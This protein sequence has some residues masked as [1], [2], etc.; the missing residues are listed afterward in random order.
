[1]SL[2]H[3]ASLFALLDMAPP[4]PTVHE[5]SESSDYCSPVAFEPLNRSKPKATAANANTP[6]LK[7]PD[8]IFKCVMDYLDGSA[9]WSLKRLC[10]GMESSITV[11]QLL[12][13]YPL[14]LSDVRDIRLGDWKYRR[15][16]VTRWVSFKESITDANRNYVQ[17][18]AMSHF[19]SI[20]DFR[21]IEEHLPSLTCLDIS[22]IKDFVWTPEE[23]W[24]WKMMAEACPKLFGRLEEL[25]VANWADYTAHS[26]IEYS[27]SYNDY[28]FK[29][30]FRISRRRDG[31]SVAKMIFPICTKLKLLAIRERY[32]GFHTWNEWEVHQRVCCLVDG[33]EKYCPESMTK[34][35][36]H[37]YAPYRSLFSTDATPWKRL[38]HVEIGLSSWMEDRRD[39]D[40]IGPIPYRITQGAHH[41]EEEEAFDDKSYEECTRDH[42]ALGNNVVQ[43][44]GASFEDLLQSLQTISKKYPNISITPIRGLQNITLHPFHL[45]NVMQRRN[46]FMHINQGNN[47]N[48]NSQAQ[49]D[50]VS[51]EVVQTALRWLAQKCDWKPTL[52]WD[53]MMCDVFPANL[54]PSRTFLPKTDVL[55][56][57][58]TMVATLRTLDIPIRV[59]IGDRTNTCPSSGLDGSLYFGDYKSFVGEGENKREVLLPTQASFNLTAIAD[60]VDELTIQYPVDVPGV[61][62][63]VR[64]GKRPTAAEKGLMQREMI[65]WRR[66]W[67]RYSSQFKNLKKLTADV[68]NDIYEDWGKSDL[69]TLLADERWDMLEIEDRNGDFGLFGNYFPFSSTSLRYI[70]SRKRGRSKFVQRVFFRLDNEPLTLPSMGENTSAV[71]REQ[72]EVTDEHIRGQMNLPSVADSISAQERDEGA[73]THRHIRKLPAL[74]QHISALE[75]EENEI[76]D[77]HIQDIERPAH[78]FWPPRESE[79]GPKR[80]RTEDS[81]A[82]KTKRQKVNEEDRQ[83]VAAAANQF[84]QA[85]L[86][87]LDRTLERLGDF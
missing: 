21:W 36:I 56:R 44:V 17:K 23:T 68:P 38:T 7:L 31:G 84:Q 78:R 49:T 63:W 11:N 85:T 6:L 18:L 27:Y 10:K 41:R 51:N 42:M 8:D 79:K 52:A 46:P 45:V 16:G 87:H 24:T 14:Q 2:A 9:A 35:R 69:S 64:S 4:S 30:K 65:G 26:R 62:G 5:D 73:I 50:P 40:V 19:A 37:D 58:R 81:D 82:L 55:S 80:K 20:D 15:M 86:A 66:F 47:N 75:R 57:I 28:R 43:G 59:S 61:S 48:N 72:G 60:M 33:I 83:K 32:S 70:S 53:N 74:P 77:E 34:L 76:T 1:M 67:K 12:Y 71:E 25:E 39:R 13:K 22:A 29:Q 54:E 3:S